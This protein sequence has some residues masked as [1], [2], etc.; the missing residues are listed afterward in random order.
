MCSLPHF[1]AAPAHPASNSLPVCTVE[2]CADAGLAPATI[3]RRAALSRNRES[4]NRSSSTA[5]SA[6]HLFRPLPPASRGVR[7][8]ARAV[9]RNSG[10]GKRLL[11]FGG[12]EKLRA[13][14]EQ[15]ACSELQPSDQ[16]AVAAHLQRMQQLR[17]VRFSAC[18]SDFAACT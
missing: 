6:A 12:M 10:R 14:D 11:A 16:A 3:G 1:T 13:L 9:P 2:R 4:G 17:L 15:L 5:L 7:R 8:L 18:S